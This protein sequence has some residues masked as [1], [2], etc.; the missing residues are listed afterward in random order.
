[1]P[2]KILQLNDFYY[3]SVLATIF[4]CGIING[5]EGFKLTHINV[6]E[7]EGFIVCLEGD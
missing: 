6:F 4:K 7:L 3:F 1:M 5:F 2:L